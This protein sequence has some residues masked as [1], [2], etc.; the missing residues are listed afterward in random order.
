MNKFNYFILFLIFWFTESALNAEFRGPDFHFIHITTENGLPSNTVRDITQD[1]SGFMWFA[2][3]GGLVRFDGKNSKVFHLTSSGKKKD[4][5]FVMK[6]VPYKDGLLVGTDHGLY[7]YSPESES[8]ALL[9]LQFSEGVKGNINGRVN[10][11][12][13]DSAENIWVAIEKNGVFKITPDGKITDNFLFPET[14]N[15]INNVYIDEND[16]IWATSNPRN[17]YLYKYDRR[18]SNFRNFLLTVSNVKDHHGGSVLTSDENGDFWIGTW[19]RG[20]IK[21]NPITGEGWTYL[22]GN[23]I[24]SLHIHSL[25]KYAPGLMLVGSDSGLIL[26][27][28]HTGEYWPYFADE[29]NPKSIS[30]RFIYPIVKDSDGGIWIGTYYKGV[31]YVSKGS[32]R[33]NNWHHSK[34]KNSV[35]GNVVSRLCEDSDGKIW[36]GTVDGGLCRFNPRDN[37]FTSYPI[38]G[39]GQTDN[40]NALFIDGNK[41]W[42]GTYG[43]DAGYI[44]INTGKWKKIPVVGESHTSCYAILKDSEGRVWMGSTQ[45]LALY[46]PSKE[47][48]ERI[49]DLKS[50][51]NDIREDNNGV[52]WISTQGAGLYCY[53]HS[54][55]KWRNY[56]TSDKPGSLPHNHINSINT[57]GNKILVSTPKGLYKYNPESEKFLL[58]EGFPEGVAANAVEV[59]GEDLWVSTNQGLILLKADG[60]P[61]RFMASEG[62]GENLFLAGSSLSTQDGKIYFG[63]ISGFCSV[64]PGAF[65]NKA[66]SPRLQFTSLNIIDEKVE[67]GSPHLPSSLNTIKKLELD[68]SDHTFTI[69]FAALS[70]DNPEENQYLYRLEGFDKSWRDPAKENSA[71]YSNLPPGSYTFRVKGANSDGV[72]NNEGISLKIVVKPVWYLTTLMK[73]LYL[74]L[75]IALLLIGLRFILWRMEKSHV[76]ELERISHNK[77]KEMFRSKFSFFTVVAHE[78]RTP[79]SLIIGPLEKILSS[80]ENFSAPVREDLNVID[81][82][83]RRLLMLVNQLLDYKKVEDNNL[84]MGFRHHDIIPQIESITGRFRPSMEQKGIQL[85]VDLPVRPLEVDVDPEAI[86]KLVSNLI[87]NA[88]KFTKDSVFVKCAPIEGTDKFE[89]VVKDNGIGI[90][91]ENQDK[92]FKPFFQVLDNINEAKGGTGL[93]LSIVRSVVEAHGGKIKLESLPGA[94]AT[95]TVILPRTQKDVLPKMEESTLAAI[96]EPQNDIS[97]DDNISSEQEDPVLLVVDDNEEMVKFISGHFEK[98]YE[99]VTASNGR[100]ALERMKEKPVSLIICDWM[101]P[102]MDGEEFLK[103]IRHDENYSH[104][105]FVMLTAKTDNASKITTMKSGADAYVEKPFSI[106]YLEA[107][108]ENLLEMR[109]LLRK[110]YSQTPLEPITTIAQTEVDNELLKKLQTLIEDNFSNQNLNVDFLAE[111]LGISRSGLYAKIKTLADVTPNEL[112][113]ITRLK[114]AA[115]L[116]TENK[117]RINEICYMVGFNSSSYFSRCFQKQF[118][119]KPGEFVAKNH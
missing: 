44:D 99:V 27:N 1:K 109:S 48:F 102:V 119:M 68:N 100:E 43:N 70:Y 115:E 15:D 33:F 3:D 73:I 95:F 67:V 52:L 13:I 2:T 22:S 90:N 111:H 39:N 24:P 42:V 82:N 5:I 116:L 12:T 17:G 31:N 37:S 74:V 6:I 87:N 57:I 75:A 110:K 85:T 62:P 91:K 40:I 53:D 61:R 47:C 104:I 58:L 69:S 118:G 59:S 45:M 32:S 83:A 11:I 7:G 106:G 64:N 65:E 84:P 94:G 79:V 97:P 114:K 18:E 25:M 77:E 4:E 30:G 92:V 108:I 21:F 51:I 107:R 98:N 55:K 16:G 105:P 103:K 63:N 101:M 56:R 54:T 78:I 38:S 35:S 8:L 19:D 96:N 76:R 80:Q 26:F 41:L 88:M 10:S 28:T 50:W 117:Y 46:N 14:N 112:I 81:R 72:W 93:G 34:Y 9:P 49:S 60:K 113:Q 36:I 89:I 23:N 20:L 66:E 29:L 71:T 86:T